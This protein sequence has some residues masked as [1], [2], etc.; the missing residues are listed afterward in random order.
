MAFMYMRCSE[1]AGTQYRVAGPLDRRERTG[2]AT[3]TLRRPWPALPVNSCVALVSAASS[4][5]PAAAGAVG[6]S[7]VDYRQQQPLLFGGGIL[8]SGLLPSLNPAFCAARERPCLPP[9]SGGGPRLLAAAA[10]RISSLPFRSMTV[11]VT[12]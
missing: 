7:A 3:S 11:S 6:S 9:A 1:V 5:T 8:R 10:V 4:S 2:H 12:F